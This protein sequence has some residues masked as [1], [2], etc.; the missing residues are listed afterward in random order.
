LLAYIKRTLHWL[1]PRF[2]SQTE[3]F[4]VER[5]ARLMSI[6]FDL[7]DLPVI[8]FENPLQLA[9]EMA[10]HVG[11]YTGVWGAGRISTEGKP[12]RAF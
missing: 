12:E 8:K 9:Q 6:S 7:L 11:K 2:F 1:I 3:T 5:G 10:H 4:T